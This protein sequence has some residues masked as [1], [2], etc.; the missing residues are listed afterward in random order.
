MYYHS[1]KNDI[2]IND[3]KFLQSFFTIISIL[4]TSLKFHL[5]NIN[6]IWK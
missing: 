3:V 6:I 1:F 4:N 5:H 2:D